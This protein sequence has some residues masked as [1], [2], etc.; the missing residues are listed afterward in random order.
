MSGIVIPGAWGVRQNSSG[1]SFHWLFGR[2]ISDNPYVFTGR[3]FPP[4]VRHERGEG[5]GRG[6]S[7]K[8]HL[9]SPTISSIVPLEEKEQ[10]LVRFQ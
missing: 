10:T 2:K 6:A 1:R 3:E 7:Q 5:E 9:L 8:D 4:P